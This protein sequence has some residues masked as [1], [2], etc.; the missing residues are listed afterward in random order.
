MSNDKKTPDKFP[1][2]MVG[3]DGKVI[4]VYGVTTRFVEA[5]KTPNWSG[6]WNHTPEVELWQAS[7][8]SLN[9]DPHLMTH[10]REGWMNGPGGG[11]FLTDAS[12]PNKSVK[13][14]YLLRL[15]LLSKNLS[16]RDFF[17][18]CTLNMAS[19]N[20]CGVLLSEFAAW[21]CDV[22][23]W[24]DLPPELVAIAD[25]AKSKE[26]RA[27]TVAKVADAMM[28]R[29]KPIERVYIIQAAATHAPVAPTAST[30]GDNV[31]P[32]KLGA[33]DTVIEDEQPEQDTDTPPYRTTS[34]LVACFGGYMGV[35]NPAKVLSEYPK[36]ATKNGALVSRGKRGKPTNANPDSSA[37]NPV[38]FALN[39]LDKKP[40]PHL[41]GIGNL[42]QQHLDTVFSMKS[43][44]EWKPI[45]IANKPL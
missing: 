34:D 35:D 44:A 23:K 31:A 20:K 21:A 40:L 24:P 1:R 33:G 36:W 12:F 3:P 9:L 22:V 32:A 37:W 6:E 30:T 2:K 39:L 45:W 38:Q 10:D 43:L 27:R 25:T 26:A 7:L 4:T 28:A 29:D 8:L 14:E 42:K 11:P 13:D 16:N 18:P 19:P 41:S 15:R 5:P 17:S